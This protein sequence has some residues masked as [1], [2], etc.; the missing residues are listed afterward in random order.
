MKFIPKVRIYK[1]SDILKCLSFNNFINILK[2]TADKVVCYWNTDV[3]NKIFK[4][5]KN[6][7]VQKLLD[8]NG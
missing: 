7:L 3:S 8:T 5:S 1:N 2:F 6:N 4:I